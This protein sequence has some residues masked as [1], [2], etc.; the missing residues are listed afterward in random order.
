MK[1]LETERL[2]LRYLREDDYIPLYDAWSDDEVTKYL[3]FD[4]YENIEAAKESVS[5][6]IAL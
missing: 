2:K 5:S 4:T 6:I 3:S 1:E